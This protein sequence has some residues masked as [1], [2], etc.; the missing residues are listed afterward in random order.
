MS[1]LTL[2]DYEMSSIVDLL[3]NCLHGRAKEGPG[4][5]S[6][7]T[8]GLKDVLYFVKCILSAPKNRELF[9]TSGVGDGTRLNALLLKTIARYSLLSDGVSGAMDA[10]VVEHAVVALYGMTLYGLDEA[11]IGFSNPLMGQ[12]RSSDAFL[13]ATFG[14]GDDDTKT[15]ASSAVAKVLA[16][17]LKK[18]GITPAGRH[19]ANQI[20][21]RVKSLRFEGSAG[22]LVSSST[23]LRCL[24]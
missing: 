17:Y 21:F 24:D 11:V 4:G 23:P 6:S 1:A 13:P 9:A 22:A 15:E 16:A 12:Q 14:D 2:S 18:E 10:N 20:L 8:F 3:A 19:A 7:A 5:Y